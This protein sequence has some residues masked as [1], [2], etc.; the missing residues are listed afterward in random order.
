MI[1]ALFTPRWLGALLLSALF[2][3]AAYFLGHWQYGRHIEKAE[4]NE[5]ISSYYGAPAVP[6]E[7]VATSAPLPRPQEWRHVSLRGEFGS[8]ELLVRART[9]DGD[10]GYEVVRPF[11]LA[12]GA[13]VLVDRGWV[14]LG[15]KGADDV[16]T[17]APAPAGSVEVTGWVRPGERS[18][19]RASTSGQLASLNLEEAAAATGTSLLGAYVQLAGPDTDV[20]PPPAGA[21]SGTITPT[22]LGMP[23]RSLGPH[24][25]YAYQWWIAMPAGFILVALGI[26]REL[27]AGPVGTPA[28]GAPR[29]PGDPTSASQPRPRRTRIWDEEDE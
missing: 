28:G 3:V 8:P 29:G 6:I 4:R 11:R 1:R 19:G 15:D 10:V 7:S 14:P 16:P 5:R 20:A 21:V 26:R 9:Y 17:I 2:A 25:A 13:A 23:D 22:P 18:R 24:Q 12:S 27:R